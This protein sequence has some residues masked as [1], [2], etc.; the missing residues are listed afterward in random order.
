MATRVYILIETTV[1]KTTEVAQALEGL[2]MMTSVDT[3]TGPFNI[4]GVAEAENLKSIGDLISDGMHRIPGIEKTITC[5][6][7]KN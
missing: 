7:V 5:L 4:I 2:K 6:S 1:G 3:V